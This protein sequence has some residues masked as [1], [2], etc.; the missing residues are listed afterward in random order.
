MI[1]LVDVNNFYVS[2]QRAFEPAMEGR[3]IV[4][5][6]NN[7]G[8]VIARSNEAKALGIKM[9]A[10]WHQ[11]RELVQQH[12]IVH[13]SSN[14]ALYAD[15]S[16]RV[17]SVL[18]RF[19]PDQEVY[20]IDES[21]LGLDGMP[22]DLTD[23]G[24]EIRTTVRRWTGLPVCVGIGSTKTLAKLANHL[25]KKRPEFGGVCELAK[26]PPARLQAIMAEVDVGDVWGVGRKIAARLAGEGINT[27]A[28][29]AAADAEGVANRYSVVLQRTVLELCGV[30][31]IDLETAAPDKQQIMCARSFGQPVFTRGELASA[32]S[33]Y[34]ARAAEKLRKQGSA[35][36]GLMVF[37]RTNPFRPGDPQYS[38]A[39]T[40]PLTTA[41]D[42]TLLLTRAAL[43]TLDRIFLPGYRYAKAGVMLTNL[44]PRDTVQRHLFV[45][46]RVDPGKRAALNAVIDQANRRYGRGS[47][48][49]ASALDDKGWKMKQGKVSPHWTTVWAD[50]P[51]VH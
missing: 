8:C 44:Q 10:P 4:V 13:Y 15:M 22:G 42:D 19:S 32:L 6:S 33:S 26:I 17:M 48:K 1:A 51:V 11:L 40:V 49:L 2:C 36:G 35:A 12:G 30:P 18:G 23:Y 46:D 41:S 37:I 25:A 38:P 20:S 28:D 14:Y 45:E 27:V 9:G 7:D 21:F 39:V 31:C 5:L 47:L 3:T 16:N 43:W 29:L 50:V 24:Q 34:V